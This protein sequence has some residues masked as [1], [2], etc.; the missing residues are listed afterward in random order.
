MTNDE[1]MTKPEYTR[2]ATRPRDSALEWG[3]LLPLLLLR[4]RLKNGRGL[5]QS[6]IWRHANGTVA[7]LDA[8]FSAHCDHKP[9]RLIDRR[10][11]EHGTQTIAAFYFRR[12]SVFRH[13]DFLRHSTFVIRQSEFVIRSP[14]RRWS[15]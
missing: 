3:S 7:S 15:S 13:S 6:K 11:V 2:P 1:R 14:A 10:E 8:S 4:A 5:A 9:S 12:D